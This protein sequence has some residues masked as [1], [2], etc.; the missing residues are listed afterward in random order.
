MREITEQTET[1]DGEPI[2]WRTAPWEGTPTLYLHGVPTGS[3]DW[4]PFLERTGG[5]A[6]DLPGFG[7]STKRGTREFTIDGQ[8][9]FIEWFLDQRGLDEVN[10]VVH[11]WGAVGLAWA[12]AHPERVR[13]LVIIDAVPFLPGYR[14]HR[15]ARVWRTPGLGELSMGLTFKWTFRL[16][17]RESNAAPGPLPEALIDQTMDGFDLGTQRAILQL[18]R[19]SPPA[20]LEQAGSR[21]GEITCPALVVWGDRDPYIAPHFADLYAGALGGPVEVLHLEDAGHWPWL[22][23]PDLVETVAGFLAGEPGATR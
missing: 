5:L 22:D 15:T 10:L 2:F 21:L 9:E 11:D 16:L 23:R 3:F 7:R 4:I 18:Y 19:T 8:A 20:R 17:S 13:R 6:P 12:Q 1:V 14:W